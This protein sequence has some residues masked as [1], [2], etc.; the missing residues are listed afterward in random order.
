MW[1]SALYKKFVNPWPRP[2]NSIPCF[3][4][5]LTST[6]GD[7]GYRLHKGKSFILSRGIHWY[8]PNICYAHNSTLSPPKDAFS[9]FH[10]AQTPRYSPVSLIVFFV[11]FQA[12]QFVG[13]CHVT[14][15]A[16]VFQSRCHFCQVIKQM[17]QISDVTKVKD[18]G[19]G[20]QKV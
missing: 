3:L 14:Q 1:P 18:L 9:F 4:A 19:P 6:K 2:L 12:D 11:L 15:Q 16:E 20:R 10:H 13:T 7:N 8:L 17:L 5:P